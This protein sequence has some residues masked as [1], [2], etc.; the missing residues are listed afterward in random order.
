MKLTQELSGVRSSLNEK[1]GLISK[2]RV[3][4]GDAAANINVKVI[5]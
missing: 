3:E 1:D 2:L 4:I 5:A